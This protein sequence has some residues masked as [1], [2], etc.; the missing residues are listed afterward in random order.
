MLRRGHLMVR[1]FVQVV[2]VVAAVSSCGAPPSPVDE[3]VSALVDAISVSRLERT[4]QGLA[5][6]GTRN[7]LSDTESA[8][9]GIGAARE[10]IQREL[11]QAGARLQVGFDVHHLEAQG[12]LTRP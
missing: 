12:R 3:R 6:F 2:L 11:R 1:H 4:V 5:A 8:T 10:W 7:T 9:H